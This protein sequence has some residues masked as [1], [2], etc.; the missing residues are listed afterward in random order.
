MPARPPDGGA[1][2]LIDAHERALP[3][4]DRRRLGVHY[5]PSSLADEV[6]DVA[7]VALD[8]LPTS[9]C[10]PSCGGGAFL[11]AVAERLVREGVD[12]A[13]VWG[14]LSGMEI[15]PRSAQVAR[16]ALVAWAGS[17]GL[18]RRSDEARIVVGDALAVSAGHWPGVPEPGVDLVL[19]NPPFLSQLSRSTARSS[20]Q[21]AALERRFGKVGAYV[22]TAALFVRA[23]L[24]LLAPTGVLGMVQPQSFL[25]TRDTG[26]L[27]DGLL[28]DADLVALWGSDQR[29]FAD[30]DV[31]VVVPVLRRRAAEGDVPARR[32]DV[33]WEGRQPLRYRTAAPVPGASWGAVLGTAMGIPEVPAGTGA[34]VSSLA[35]ATAGFRDEY[36][37]LR[38][39]ATGLRD[40]ATGLRDAATGSGDAATGSGDAA[41]APLVTV[42]MIDPLRLRWGVGTHR[43]GGRDVHAPVVDL[44]ELERAAPRVARWAR[45]RRRPKVLVA[46]QTKVV[47]VVADPTGDLVPMTPVISVEPVEHDVDV[48]R[49][50]AALSAPPVA[51]QALRDHLGAGRSPGSL[52]WSAS[53][54]LAAAL[55]SDEEQW[56]AGAQLAREL[57]D[58]DLSPERHGRLLEELAVVMTRAHGLPGDHPVVQWWCER[59]PRR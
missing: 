17:H 18:T 56:M 2:A 30:A 31:Q 3:A 48:W 40:A 55:P 6:V 37:A 33:R 23:G 41:T 47:E 8:R 49:L 44:D 52:R 46:T 35:T 57:G 51:A 13:D 54:V 25:S 42:G 16:E 21:R 36:Y 11:L 45:A 22:D 43:L 39:A 26:T 24:D 14:R 7:L 29:R 59:R 58:R 38:D 1:R 53:A 9:V 15:D 5:T 28:A 12:P 27:R 20:E 4:A 10:D 34:V 50:A 32:T 19:G